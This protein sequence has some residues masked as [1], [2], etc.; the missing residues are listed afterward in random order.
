MK[1]SR[2]G[3]THYSIGKND[4]TIIWNPN[5]FHMINVLSK[6]I[7]FN[8]DHGITDVLI[9]LVEW[10]KTQVRRADRKLIIH[11]DNASPILLK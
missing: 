6:G 1:S 4:V 7:K 3:T 11:A 2:D 8:A 5:G 9:P 10:R